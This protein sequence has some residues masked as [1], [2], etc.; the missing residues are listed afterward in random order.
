MPETLQA[1]RAGPARA[2]APRSDVLLDRTDELDRIDSALAD[3]WRGNGRLVVVEGPSG[4]GKTALLAAARHAAAGRSMRVVHA[5]GSQLESTFAY[6]VVRQLFEPILVDA[7]EFERAE[8]LHGDVAIAA[9]FLGLPGA[10]AAGDIP[11]PRVDPSFAVLH[12]LHWLLVNVAAVTPTL[13]VIDDA[14]WADVPSLQ[15][16]SF[17]LARLPQLDVALVVGARTCDA[18]T[19]PKLLATVT[20]D[21]SAT[22][23][24]PRRLTSAAAADLVEATFGRAPD[25][26]LVEALMQATRG[27]PFLLRDLVDALHGEGIAPTAEAVADVERIGPRTV[28]RSLRRRLGRLPAPA[29]RLAEA[30]SVLG[31]SDLSTAARLAKLDEDVAA[32]AA[33]Q[34]V[35]AAVIQAAPSSLTFVHAIVREGIYSELTSIELAHAHRRAARL[36]AQ[37]PSAHEAVAE[38]LLLAEPTGD[39]WVVETLVE[40][41]RR[42][43]SAGA[44][45]HGAVLLRRALEEPPPVDGHWQLLLELGSAEASAALDGW[46][47]HLRRAVDTAPDGPSAAEAARVLARGLNRAQRFDEAV[48]VLDSAAAA[49][50]SRTSPLAVRLEAAAVVVGMNGAVAGPTMAARRIALRERAAADPAAAP[51][52]LGVAAFIAALTNEPADV[53]ADLATRALSAAEPAAPS[54][55]GRPWVSRESLFVRTTLALLVTERYD[56]VSPV[57]DRSL[58]RARRA[59]DSGMVAAGLAMRGWLALRRGDLCAAEADART[60]LNAT[61]LPAPRMY[62]ALNGGVLVKALHDQGDLDAAEAALATLDHLTETGSITAAVLRLSR[63]RLRAAQGDVA[64]ALADFLAVG[65]L[66]NRVRVTSP[67]YLPW[68][69]EAALA[70]LRLGEREPAVQLAEEEL[71]LAE[72]FGAPRALGVAKRAAGLAG[73][74]TRGIKLMEEAV[75]LFTRSDAAVERARALADLGAMLRRGNRRV[76]ARGILREAL[77]LAHRMGADRLSDETETELRATGA[78]PRRLLLSG[79]ESLTASERRVADLAERGLTNREI[80]QTLFVTARTVEG[81]LTSVFRKLQLDSRAGLRAALAGD[82]G[83]TA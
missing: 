13:V 42:S 53:A 26:V 61:D 41:A 58:D 16:L 5:R 19:D 40:A 68:R 34:L 20:A 11:S 79:I 50:D 28:G 10:I 43:I 22:V 21:P 8:L 62:R 35:S 33:E 3:A 54:V 64:A 38:H 37:Q 49:L 36:V 45:E 32:E 78:R 75:E 7:D 69:S 44:P 76:E 39:E 52:L 67:G 4:I 77:D 60:A 55:A 66:L 71:A 31:E 63:G 25:A 46:S 18:G 15:Y 59:G 1:Q 81:H 56:Q 51:E 48:E 2:R 47:D 6:G 74:G 12:G 57:V 9:A 29:L 30:L 23:I 82:E 72:A 73:G 80:A 14:Q 24:R 70:H 83:L 27:T 17:L 65:E